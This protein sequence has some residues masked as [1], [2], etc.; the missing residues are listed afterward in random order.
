MNDRV[1]RLRTESFET[2]ITISAERA[3]LIT[4]FYRENIGKYSVPMMRAKALAYLY[5]NQ[6]IYIGDDELVVGARGPR[7]RAVATYPELTCHSEEDLRILNSRAMTSYGV[8]EDDIR[9]YKEKVIPFWQGRTMREHI[10][11]G[12]SQE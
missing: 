10:F 3:E 11:D 12:L 2:P 5:E 4:D 7:P 1:K 6:T 8:S 9:I